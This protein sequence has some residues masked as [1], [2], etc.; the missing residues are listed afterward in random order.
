MARP[1]PHDMVA[2]LRVGFPG[3]PTYNTALVKRHPHPSKA[4]VKRAL[5]QAAAKLVA[6]GYH[7]RAGDYAT[8]ALLDKE[9]QP[10]IPDGYSEITLTVEP[11]VEEVTA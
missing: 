10:G 11:R 1:Q 7:L 2:S 6:E 3:N 9:G 5:A 8:H 4:A